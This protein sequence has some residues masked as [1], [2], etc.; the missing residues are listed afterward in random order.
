MIARLAVV[1]C[2]GQGPIGDSGDG[3]VVSAE[4]EQARVLA[5]E[6]QREREKAIRRIE[7]WFVQRGV[8]H[9]TRDYS[10]TEDV[11]T[12]AS[13]FLWFWFV[14]ALIDIGQSDSWARELGKAIVG[15]GAPLL[16][17][18]SSIVGFPLW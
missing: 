8:P 6:R 15:V 2:R 4:G 17:W 13:G 7:C 18:I 9:F 5:R 1:E 12:R 16:G 3:R 14:I 10:A 11:F